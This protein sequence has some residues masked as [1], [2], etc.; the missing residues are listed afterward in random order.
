MAILV[1]SHPGT[2]LSGDNGGVLSVVQ[3]THNDSPQ[4]TFLWAVGS[5]GTCVWIPRLDAKP[6][7]Y[8]HHLNMFWLN[9]PSHPAEAT[10]LML[11]VGGLVTE[12]PRKSARRGLTAYLC[13]TCLPLV[14]SLPE[15]HSAHQH[16]PW[17]NYRTYG[18][19]PDSSWATVNDRLLFNQLSGPLLSNP[20]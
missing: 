20:S 16:S 4:P 12:L 2:W 7:F 13:S 14:F 5:V 3:V 9:A 19:S 8:S 6:V 18:M 17:G 10:A 15:S 1:C 11:G